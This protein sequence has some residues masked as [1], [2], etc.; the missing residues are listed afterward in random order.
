MAGPASKELTPDD[1][2]L[3]LFNWQISMA[4]DVLLICK[5]LNLNL[6]K[7]KGFDTAKFYH[8][9]IEDVNKILKEKKATSLIKPDEELAKSFSQPPVC[10]KS[11]RNDD[12]FVYNLEEADTPAFIPL[13]QAFYE[14]ITSVKGKLSFPFKGI[15]LVW[16]RPNCFTMPSIRLRAYTNPNDEE[17]NVIQTIDSRLTFI[18]SVDKTDKEF[19]PKF[20]EGLITTKQCTKT[21][22]VKI[23]KADLPELWGATE[24]VPNPERHES[25]KFSGCIFLAPS[26]SYSF[27]EKGSPSVDWRVDTYALNRVVQSKSEEV[28]DAGDFLEDENKPSEENF[29]AEFLGNE[30]EIDPDALFQ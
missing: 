13:M 30:N 6:T 17:G 25:A 16:K 5:I 3:I 28:E 20:P 19:N 10:S 21:K 23:T 9:F 8:T 29:G 1:L 12:I 24:F 7:Y 27:H 15:E 11:K 18:T 22:K 2:N 26:L 14:S 4:M